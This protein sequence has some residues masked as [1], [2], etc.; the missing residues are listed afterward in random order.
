[1][2]LTLIRQLL[3]RAAERS[4]RVEV[5]ADHTLLVKGPADRLSGAADATPGCSCGQQVS[6][7][8]WST[9]AKT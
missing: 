7:T 8:A 3:R 2:L 6:L 1:M 9:Y 4:V 5:L